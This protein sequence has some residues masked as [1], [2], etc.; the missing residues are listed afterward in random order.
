MQ[1]RSVLSLFLVAACGGD[2][3]GQVATPLESCAAEDLDVAA[4]C[5]GNTSITASASEAT[6][7]PIDVGVTYAISGPGAGKRG[8]V[9][10]T[11]ALSGTF[12]LYSSDDPMRVCDV[13]PLCRSTEL[14]CA[15]LDRAARY[16][17]VA[18]LPYVIELRP[19]A[20]T[21]YLHVAAPA[22]D[23][24]PD[25]DPQL[26]FAPPRFHAAGTT[27]YHVTLGDLD[28]DQDLDLAVATPDDAD[29][30]TTIDLLRNDGAGAFSLVD[31]IFTS[32][33]NRAVIAD[34][35]LDGRNDIAGIGWDG[36]GALPGYYLV[37]QGDFTFEN[38]PWSTGIDFETHGGVPADFDEDGTPELLSAYRDSNGVTDVGGFVILDVP[39][40]TPVQ[41]EPAFG[42]S[43]GQAVAGDL[44]G[45][46][47]QDVLV[48]R[49]NDST[50]RFHRGDG[51]GRVAFESELTMDAP[52]RELFAFDLDAD[53]RSELVSINSTSI[54][55]I[56]G[57]TESVVLTPLAGADDV[58]A[59]DLDGDGRVDLA[60][61]GDGGIAI[62]V[63]RDSG[64]E[65]ALVLEAPDT[66]GPHSLTIGDV[67]GDGRNDITATALDAIAVYLAN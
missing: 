58:A 63:A 28:G 21:A 65:Q 25:P 48:A 57:L 12:T 34:W 6:A 64:F 20:T 17:V 44:D 55:V 36:Q 29:G 56:S 43:T 37:N 4:V 60:F 35:D 8:Y 52:I 45:D 11:S 32:A 14:D 16:D 40:F 9:V 26:A 19:Q 23:P 1:Q 50:V 2:G 18:G 7:T 13:E 59:G 66:A 31:Q 49:F 47:H 61:I 30:Q 53:G 39:A 42:A 22:D 67:N 24:D 27:P 38:R 3:N 41:D 62:Y 51:S 33:P 46:G 54:S 5:S 15:H 10:F